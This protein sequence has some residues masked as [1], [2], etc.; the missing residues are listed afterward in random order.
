MDLLRPEIDE[1]IVR[2]LLLSLFDLAPPLFSGVFCHHSTSKKLWKAPKRKPPAQ[3]MA[4]QGVSLRSLWHSCGRELSELP[5]PRNLASVLGRLLPFRVP[6]QDA[7]AAASIVASEGEDVQCSELTS[8]IDAFVAGCEVKEA[9]SQT[10]PD[11]WQEV[12]TRL[13]CIPIEMCSANR[14]V[15]KIENP[16]KLSMDRM[17]QPEF[18]LLC[19]EMPVLRGVESSAF[20]DTELLR[21]L[22]GWSPPL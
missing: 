4:A 16:S 11:S 6:M 13:L 14:H 8:V 12:S 15:M 10:C 19:D 17:P 1:Q 20:S 21:T 22:P 7:T 9:A 3:A 2:K 5:S 18:Q